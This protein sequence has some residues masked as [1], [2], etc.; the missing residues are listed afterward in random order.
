MFPRPVTAARRPRV[1]IVDD[2]PAIRIVLR[3]LLNGSGL[4]EVVEAPD[5]ETALDLIRAFSPDAVLCDL[6]M[7]GMNGI[8]LLRRVKAMDDTVAFVVITGAGTTHDAVEALRLQADDYLS[9][10]FQV[11]E[12]LHSLARALDHRRLLR[13]NR[14]YQLNLEA[15]VRDQ[16]E[17]M[18]QLFI[19]ALL[20]IANAVETRD[21][22]TGGHVERVTLYAVATGA[23]LGMEPEQLRT[24]ATA[25]L[26]HDVGKIG[27]PDHVLTKPGRLSPEEYE[28][29][30]QHPTIGAGILQQSPF[31][32]SCVPGVLHHHERWDGKGY[33]G[34][35]AGD[36]ISL[37]GRILAVVDAYDA[38]V[39]TRPYRE[40]C[41]PDAAADE[42]KRCAGS[43]FDPAVVE[44]FFQCSRD[45][46]V[47]GSDVPCVHAVRQR[48][49]AAAVGLAGLMSVA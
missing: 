26:L 2:E 5:A 16:S 9:K 46:F 35:L 22:Y 6:L 48:S 27:I 30:Q 12:V 18:E 32:Q 14:D 10:P 39:T 49:A 44:A 45:G 25:A 47:A 37:E 42:L 29:M 7:P 1:L 21:G 3:T 11:D 28:V 43:Q 24:L 40:R 31:L 20:T 15:R 34:R 17:Q 13:E 23:A 19:D 38:M 33:P 8:E 4:Y 36:G 41:D